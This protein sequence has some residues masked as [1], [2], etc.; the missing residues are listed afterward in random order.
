MYMVETFRNLAT[1]TGVRGILE[2]DHYGAVIS[3][4]ARDTDVFSIQVFD[5]NNNKLIEEIEYAS[6]SEGQIGVGRE[7]LW[8]RFKWNVGTIAF[9]TGVISFAAHFSSSLASGDWTPLAR[10]AGLSVLGMIA[11]MEAERHIG[12][13]GAIS[14]TLNTRRIRI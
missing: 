11:K 8:A 3:P 5:L 14:R 4:D 7:R 2:P 12:I 1:V 13:T 9:Y 6:V 10:Y